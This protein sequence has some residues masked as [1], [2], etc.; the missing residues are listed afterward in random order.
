M[1]LADDLAAANQDVSG[2]EAV[3]FG[4]TTYSGRKTKNVNKNIA[5]LIVEIEIVEN[6]QLQNYLMLLL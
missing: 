3:T 1:D 5:E 2:A 4:G 6:L